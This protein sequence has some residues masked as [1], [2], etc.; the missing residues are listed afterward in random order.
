MTNTS[1]LEKKLSMM[2]LRTSTKRKMNL[3][4]NGQPPTKRARWAGFNI[5]D[6]IVYPDS[7]YTYKITLDDRIMQLA[8]DE[9]AAAHRARRET[10]GIVHMTANNITRKFTGLRGSVNVPGVTSSYHVHPGPYLSQDRNTSGDF[11]TPSEQDIRGYLSSFPENQ[12][13][14]IFDVSGITVIDVPVTFYSGKINNL[15]N[16]E[17]IVKTY[18][19]ILTK[20]TNDGRLPS[21]L[22]NDGYYF[23][24]GT[25]RYMYDEIRKKTNINIVNI[26]YTSSPRKHVFD[27]NLLSPLENI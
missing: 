25:P 4:I 12:L 1:E 24:D 22:N 26:P 13:H 2:N 23:H 10:S 19:D 27:I 7:G 14:F 3:S 5:V 15:G 11:T 18:T 6:T 8:R 16:I 21:Y 20:Y 9:Y 17:G